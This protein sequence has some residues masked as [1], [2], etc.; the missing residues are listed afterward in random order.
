VVSWFG[1]IQ[2]QDFK[3]AKWAVGLRGNGLT[4]AAVERAY[5]EG[6]ILR[7]HVLRPTW[8]FVA[9]ADIRWLIALTGPRIIARMGPR[10]RQ[11]ELDSTTLARSRATLT[12]ALGG[13]GLTRRQ[14]GCSSGRGS[15]PRRSG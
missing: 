6:A 2:A 12:R 15:G 11:L 4:E 10:H 9:A 7:T 3:G 14:I 8:H 13:G 5:D 1:A